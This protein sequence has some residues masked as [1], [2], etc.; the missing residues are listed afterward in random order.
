M[1]TWY[2]WR[3]VDEK[4]IFLKTYGR[5][6]MSELAA[7]VIDMFYIRRIGSVAFSIEKPVACEQASVLFIN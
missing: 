1:Y 3:A 6:E 7:S 4:N 5:M 2:L